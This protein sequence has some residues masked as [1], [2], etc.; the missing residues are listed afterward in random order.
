MS[1]KGKSNRLFSLL[2]KKSQIKPKFED[3]NNNDVTDEV[4]N[5]YNDMAVTNVDNYDENDVDDLEALM[6]EGSTTIAFDIFSMINILIIT[7]QVNRF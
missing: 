2:K 3:N 7:I 1:N 4:V 5:R 6:N